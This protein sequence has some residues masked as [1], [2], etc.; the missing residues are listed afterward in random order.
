MATPVETGAGT[1]V[2]ESTESD[3][4]HVKAEYPLMTDDQWRAMR[5]VIEFVVNFKDS[6]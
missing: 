4:I 6:E 1:P 5:T 2:I 3:A